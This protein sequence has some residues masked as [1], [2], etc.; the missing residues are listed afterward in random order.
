MKTIQNIRLKFA[1]L[2]CKLNRFYDITRFMI[3]LNNAGR[4]GVPVSPRVHTNFNWLAFS[5]FPNRNS[6]RELH[7][8]CLYWLSDTEAF[9]EM[10]EI[11]SA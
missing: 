6:D 1:K 7:L 11:T 5:F 4:V 3:T 2:T 8:N 9:L 10:E